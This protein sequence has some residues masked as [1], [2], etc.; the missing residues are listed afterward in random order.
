MFGCSRLAA[1]SRLAAEALHLLL[2]GQLTGEDHLEGHDPVERHVSG[3]VDDPHAA[4]GDLL[5]QL[6]IAEEADRCRRSVAR[7][8]VPDCGNVGGL[9]CRY[10]PGKACKLFLVLEEGPQL[11]GEVGVLGQPGVARERRARLDSGQVLGQGLVDLLF[12]RGTRCGVGHGLHSQ[13]WRFCR[14][15]FRPRLSSPATAAGLRSSCR[16]ICASV[17]PCQ[18]CRISASRCA[19]GS[20]SSASARRTA[21]S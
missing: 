14:N 12:P 8:A 18:Y 4:A 19:S 13:L 3:L 6:V 15:C 20:C 1:A 9:R 17:Q 11:V 10:S 2:A 21:R 5:Q 7:R 16:P